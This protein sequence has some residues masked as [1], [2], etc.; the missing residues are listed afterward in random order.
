[1]TS[2]PGGQ[3]NSQTMMTV[4]G[5]VLPTVIVEVLLHFKR[6]ATSKIRTVGMIY[7]TFKEELYSC[8]KV[9]YKR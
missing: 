1:M 6:Y 7:M 4:G 5:G 3:I 9:S 2:L 8:Y